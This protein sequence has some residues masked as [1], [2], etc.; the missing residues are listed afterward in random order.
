M[1]FLRSALEVPSNLAPKP[2]CQGVFFCKTAPCPQ[3]PIPGVSCYKVAITSFIVL[4]LGSCP[5]QVSP[6]IG[7]VT[8]RKEHT[9]PRSTEL[10]RWSQNSKDITKLVNEQELQSTTITKSPFIR[11]TQSSHTIP[12]FKLSALYHS[13][14][15]I[16]RRVPRPKAHWYM[17]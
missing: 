2:T 3:P 9:T 10:E 6:T 5:M 17:G 1:H 13:K 16:Q 12:R 7:K 8:K 14:A 15:L 11:D 4:R